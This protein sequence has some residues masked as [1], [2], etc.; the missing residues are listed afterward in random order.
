MPVILNFHLGVLDNKCY[1]VK[2]VYPL[3]PILG[4]LPNKI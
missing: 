2:H 1:T 3:Q 4:G